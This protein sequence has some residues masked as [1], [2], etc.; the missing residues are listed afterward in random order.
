MP[1]EPP[2]TGWSFPDL[3][4]LDQAPPG[5]D[6]LA[7]GA[8]LQPGTLLAAYRAGVFPMHIDTSTSAAARGNADANV[9]GRQLGWWSPDPRGILPLPCVNV[10]RSLRQS[11]NRFTFTVDNAFTEVVAG[12]SDRGRPDGWINGEIAAAYERLHR[13]G[14]A[15][16]V[17]TWQDGSLVGGLYGV[18]IGGLFAG[19]SMFYRVRDASKAALVYLVR[20]VLTDPK[21][22]LGECDAKASSRL[23]D[24][25]WVTPHLQ[26]LGALA[27]P[28]QHYRERLQ[29]AL[30]LPAPAV[31]DFAKS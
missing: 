2:A 17:E 28:R 11:A 14:W 15:H 13:L 24:V 23:L 25:Q 7:V 1:V 29:R 10:S 5:Q 4:E 30:T 31:F 19:E 12:C 21:Q 3:G 26:S 6:L 27:V 18:A 9:D 22:L 8:D 16:S 20:Q